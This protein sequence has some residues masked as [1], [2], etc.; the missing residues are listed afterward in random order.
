MIRSEFKNNVRNIRLMLKYSFAVAPKETMGIYL[1]YTLTG[2]TPIIVGYLFKILIDTLNQGDL[3]FAVAMLP[4][5]LYIGYM[6]LA[7]VIDVFRASL[8]ENLFIWKMQNKSLIDLLDKLF[9]IDIAD[10]E[11][12]ETYNT[13]IKAR[14]SANWRTF[15][16][17]KDS[18]WLVAALAGLISSTIVVAQYNILIPF[19]L[20]FLA[21][22]G[23]IITLKLGKAAWTIYDAGGG[24]H[25]QVSYLAG[26]VMNVGYMPELRIFGVKEK[27]IGQLK[28]IQEQF[29][30][31]NSSTAIKY[32]FANAFAFVLS[33][34][35]VGIILL[36]QL[37]KVVDGQ[38][39]VGSFSFILI[40]VYALASSLEQ[41][42]TNLTSVYNRARLVSYFFDVLNL[43][44][45][46]LPPVNP[47]VPKLSTLAPKIEFKNVSF[48]YKKSD[49]YVLKNVSF[50]IEP[51]ENVALVGEN[52]A[53]KSTIIK[54]LVRFY[55][56]SEGEILINGINIKDLD[57]E[58]WYRKI[59]TLFQQFIHYNFTVKESI[60][61][62]TED[63]DLER[64]R[65]A[66]Q[67]SGAAEFI[68]QFPNKYD[69]MLGV[70][71]EEGKELSG[72]QWQKIALARA[73]YRMPVL[74][75]LDEPTSA[76]D[77]QAEFDIF[78]NI[79]E[80]YKDDKSLLIVSHRF[81]TVRNAEKIIVL[82]HGE[83]VEQGSHDELINQNG[84]YA[85][86][87]NVQAEGYK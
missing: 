44:K 77:A 81:S 6:G 7:K 41:T 82:T 69:Q 3:T 83:V 33:V 16:V 45:K 54:L 63:I 39:S 84:L 47:I 29:Y 75:I 34:V 8:I 53:G 70:N 79:N 73:F 46:V 42:V 37:Q 9:E 22:P 36:S 15:E 38:I 32:G 57:L 50:V 62:E 43:E 30:K 17:V 72:G 4:F 66:A 55:D 5:G 40:A 61:L 13:I 35:G 21:I 2:L 27:I 12:P 68:E 18:A 1:F 65:N 19:V 49:P 60:S 76:I 48:R 14:D 64:V 31:K 11:D 28:Y 59:G 67:Q 51:G 25:K 74:L 58:W 85:K 56:V 78:N 26:L 80:I 24:W 23:F 86:M 52:G 10:F 71:Y 87:F 20:L